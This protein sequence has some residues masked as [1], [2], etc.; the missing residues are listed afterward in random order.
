MSFFNP[1]VPVMSKKQSAFAVDNLPGL[2]RFHWQVNRRVILSTFYTRHDQACLLWAIV[3][4]AIFGIAQF[5]PVGWYTQVV[6][7]SGLTLLSVVGMIMLTWFFTT[8]EGL[9]WLLYCWSLLMTVGMVI[10]DLSLLLQWGQVLEQ[11]CPLWLILSGVGYLVTG[12]G[13]RSRAFLLIGIVHFL[14][15]GILPAVGMWQPLTTGVI[16]SG[17]TL[18][19]A[20]VQWDSYGVCGNPQLTQPEAINSRTSEEACASSSIS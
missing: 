5:L 8:V 6:V 20:E 4:A 15:I 1:D 2:W 16:I 10:T 12:A 7:A 9:T 19:V 14:T 3:S 13:M 17:S 18:L 11:I